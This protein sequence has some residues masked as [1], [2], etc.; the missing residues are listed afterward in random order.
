VALELQRPNRPLIW[1]PVVDAVCA[2]VPREAGAYL[3]GGVVRDAYLHRPIHDIDLATP[4]SGA[5]VARQIANALGGDYYSLDAERGVGRAIIPWEDGKII[6]DVAQFRGADL[7]EDLRLR[8]FTVNAMAVPVEGERA[9]I[10]DP[11]GGAADL[12]RKLLR[13]CGPES[14]ASDPVRGLRAIRASVDF[15][16]RIEPDTL[17][18]IRAH[19]SRLADVSP[20]R[21]RDEFLNM[22]GSAKP[23]A[24]LA[25]AAYVGLLSS[26]IP[27]LD[28]LPE[29]T[30]TAPHLYD[31][32]HHTLQTVDRLDSLL[33]IVGAQRDMRDASNVGFGT[34]A[35]ALS[36]LR[37]QLSEHLSK[38][39]PNDRPHRTLLLLAALLHDSGKAETRTVD[40]RGHVHFYGH[41]RVSRT[42]ATAVGERL[43]LS[44]DE[45]ARLAKIAGH[46]MRPHWLASAEQLTARAIYRFWRDTGPAGVDICLLAIA[47]YL[48]TVGPTLE[49]D[50]WAA[51]VETVQTLLN[52][53]FLDYERAVAPP[54]LLNGRDVMR[55]FHLKGGPE[56]GA[57]LEALRE[58]QVSGEV[59]T[60]DD[61]LDWVRRYLDNAVRN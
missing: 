9:Q 35:I 8:D 56:I 58:A 30:Q 13:R 25:A 4:G 3:V 24:A 40:E 5:P 44:R 46:H 17:T 7:L 2:V 43:R 23:G 60:R 12:E 59:H 1:S 33:R 51:Y 38:V 6:V 19:A 52:S 18:D 29:I 21:V 48:A 57:I 54:P 42:I 20:E 39:W 16:L 49:Q 27:E 15:G 26:I 14:I 28:P 55:A 53:Y 31:V 45:I 32:W 37:L 61:A 34:V 22:L 36:H 10:I 50:V 11:L 41:E 47:D